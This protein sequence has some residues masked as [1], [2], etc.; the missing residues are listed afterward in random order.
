MR[1]EGQK[2]KQKLWLLLIVLWD[3]AVFVNFVFSLQLQ[4][5]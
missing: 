1:V 2:T 3:F 5:K 4:Q